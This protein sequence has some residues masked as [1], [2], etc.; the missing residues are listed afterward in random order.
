MTQFM[1]LWLCPI[2]YDKPPILL[3][4]ARRNRC[5]GGMTY[6]SAHSGTGGGTSHATSPSLPIGALTPIILA[7]LFTLAERADKL[8]WE[9]FLNGVDRHWVYQSSEDGPAAALI[10]FQP[11]GRVPLH[12]HLGYEHIFVLGGSQTDENGTLRAGGLVINLPGTRH[13]VVSEEGC[14]VL[15]VYE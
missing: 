12:E 1:S 13:S 9:P 11:G 5:N 6:D 2:S 3:A 4:V 14:L 8:R 15:A 10:R 7:D